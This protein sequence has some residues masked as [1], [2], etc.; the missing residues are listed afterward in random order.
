MHLL[1]KVCRN[2]TLQTIRIRSCRWTAS[3]R[4]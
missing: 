2:R 1:A 3:W 4:S